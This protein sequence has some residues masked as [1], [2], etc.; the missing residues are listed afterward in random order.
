MRHQ[1]ATPRGH[2]PLR[3][4]KVLGDLAA[5]A[6]MPADRFVRLAPDQD[7]L[8]VRDHVQWLASTGD[9]SRASVPEPERDEELRH[10]SPVP[11]MQK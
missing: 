4:P 9:P 10:R 2:R 3:E 6:F 1:Q 7:E 5:Y 11:G 8:A